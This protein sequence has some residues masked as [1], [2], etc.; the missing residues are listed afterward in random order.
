MLRICVFIHSNVRH[1]DLLLLLEEPTAG[2]SANLDEGMDTL[3]S[4]AAAINNA[5]NVLADSKTIEDEV[6][7]LLSK[8][9][10]LIQR[11]RHPQL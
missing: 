11:E 7:V 6:D 3:D 5:A 2:S 1:G 4:A 9:D 10:G 8:D